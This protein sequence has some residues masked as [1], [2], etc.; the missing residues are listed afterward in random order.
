MAVKTPLIT[1]S[2][3]PAVM[4]I[5]PEPSPFDLRSSTLA[6]TPLPIRMST[7]VPMNSPRNRLSTLFLHPVERPR[8]RLLPEKI[9][10]LAT[11]RVHIRLPS[12]LDGPSAAQVFHTLVEPNR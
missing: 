1:A 11:R 7:I 4:T 3:Q 2:A 5:Q 10:T 9:H 6:T 8:D 12:A